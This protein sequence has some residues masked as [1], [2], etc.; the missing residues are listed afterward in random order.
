MCIFHYTNSIMT[1]LTDMFEKIHKFTIES[2][3]KYIVLYTNI[4][5]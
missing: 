1:I 2:D 3:N 5:K 4:L